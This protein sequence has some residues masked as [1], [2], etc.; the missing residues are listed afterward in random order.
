MTKTHVFLRKCLSSLRG[1]GLVFTAQASWSQG[2]TMYFPKSGVCVLGSTVPKSGKLFH[3]F[4]QKSKT[5]LSWFGLVSLCL[6]NKYLEKKYTHPISGS[7]KVLKNQPNEVYIRVKSISINLK[8]HYQL[9][10]PQF[11]ELGYFTIQSKE[12]AFKLM[13]TPQHFSK[14]N[15]EMLYL[16]VMP[17]LLNENY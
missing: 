7:A 17:L 11:T 2:L 16:H 12:S 10:I 14:D 13:V 8:N 1:F 5:S 15:W 4:L 6:D 3:I 9:K